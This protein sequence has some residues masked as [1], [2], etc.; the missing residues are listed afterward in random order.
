VGIYSALTGE[1][2]ETIVDR[3]A[4]QGF[5]VFKPALADITVAHLAPITARYRDILS[6]PAE[7]DRVLAK[8][9]DRARA[10]AAPIMDDVRRAVGFWRP[11]GS[12]G[13][14]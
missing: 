14:L 13:I 9:A 1:S 3:Y 12:G 4:G 6:D 2:K 7:I 11:S 8:G 5:G 10:L